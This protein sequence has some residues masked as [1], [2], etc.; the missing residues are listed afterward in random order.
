LSDKN[1][2]A[3]ICRGEN[4]TCRSIARVPGNLSTADTVTDFY[5]LWRRDNSGRC[6]DL[7]CAG[8]RATPLF[9]RASQALGSQTDSDPK[10]KRGN[11]DNT[12]WRPPASECGKQR[13]NI[14]SNPLYHRANIRFAR[15]IA[16][17]FQGAV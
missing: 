3:T 9:N 6:F 11:C 15:V 2:R 7:R 10:G 4:K 12:I 5:A 16:V 13:R 8:A 17:T 14:V 1:W